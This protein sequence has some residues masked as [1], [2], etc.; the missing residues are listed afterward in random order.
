MKKQID[1]YTDP[2]AMEPLF[3]LDESGKLET[4]ATQ[5]IQK[6]AKLSGALHPITR[7]A[8][9]NFLRPM[10]SY[11]SNLIEGHDT[12]PI[13]IAKALQGDYS[14]D[15][16]KRDL[17]QEA[18]AHIVLHEAIGFDLQSDNSIEIYNTEFICNIHKRFYEHLPE[19]F[20]SIKSKE[21]KS[22]TVIPGKLR[23]DEVEVGTH[24]APHSQYLD[25]F[26]NRFES[27]YNTNNKDNKSKI[28]RVISIAAAHHRLAWIHPFLDGNGRVVRLFSDAGFMK[29]ELDAS[30]LWSISRG[31]AR[32]NSLYKTALANADNRRF[33]DYDG[34]GNLSNKSL[35]AFCEFFLSTAIDQVEY[36]ENI[37]D[38]NNMIQRIE[39][40]VDIMVIRNKMRIE[41]KHILIDIFLKGKISKV[42]AMRITNLSDK[43]LKILTDQLID[44]ELVVARKEGIQIMYYVNYPINYSPML[45]PGIYPSDKE[46]EMMNLI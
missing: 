18:K 43:T 9:A 8:I 34:R 31:L 5:L 25:T 23:K 22:K 4:L 11:Y 32:N 13:D 37:L 42:D 33:N 36:M 46:S 35:V 19:S 21:G 15:K 45:F 3:P 28:R 38:I 14:K 6:S 41:S 16:L 39:N 27:F 20:K 7:R 40:F 26:M 17:Q 12:H 2:S 29:E 44:M 24:I 10:N 30:G 1:F